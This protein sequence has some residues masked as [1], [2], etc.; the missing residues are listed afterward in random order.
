MACWRSTDA[1]ATHCVLFVVH[2]RN[3]SDLDDDGALSANEFC[4]ATH[5]VFNRLSGRELPR[6]LP[7]ELMLSLQPVRPTLISRRERCAADVLR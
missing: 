6:R 1:R 3:M 2:H 7:D 5:L 4:I